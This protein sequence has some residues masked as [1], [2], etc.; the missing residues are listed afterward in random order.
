MKTRPKKRTH[1]NYGLAIGC[2]RRGVGMRAME[3]AKAVGISTGH[4]SN[5][6]NDWIA[7]TPDEAKKIDAVLAEAGA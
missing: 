1:R 5:I 2:R 3:L 4:L 6:E 7:P